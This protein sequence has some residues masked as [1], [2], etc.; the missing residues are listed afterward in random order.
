MQQTA[1]N[2]QKSEAGQLRGASNSPQS[3]PR[4]AYTPPQIEDF[5]RIADLTQTLQNGAPG[6]SFGGSFT[7]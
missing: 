1:S 2:N 5:G 3:G 4:K 6:D 7:A